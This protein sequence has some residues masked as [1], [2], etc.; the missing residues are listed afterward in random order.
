MEDGKVVSKCTRDGNSESETTSLTKYGTV[1]FGQ[2]WQEDT[3]GDGVCDTNDAKQPITWQILSVDS[4]GNA[5]LL[6]DKILEKRPYNETDTS[7]TWET[8]ALRTWLNGTASGEFL[9]DAFTAKQR[10]LIKNDTVINND[11]PDTANGGSGGNDTID[12]I[13]VLSLDEILND[14]YGFTDKDKRIASSTGFSKRQYFGDTYWLRT[15]GWA[16]W[17]NCLTLAVDSDGA[18]GV[19][20]YWN[21]NIKTIG[22]RP[23]LRVKLSDIQ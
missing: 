11:H 21:C 3:N 16:V 14:S 17:D 20:G 10:A 7:V 23:A 22:V 18:I 9:R 5:L 15:P 12:R 2:Y 1:Q 6:S 19:E 8:C 13:F 4:S